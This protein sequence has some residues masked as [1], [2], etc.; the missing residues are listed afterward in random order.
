VC[1]GKDFRDRRDE[2]IVR[3]M[4]ETGARAGEVVAMTLDDVDLGHGSAVVRRGK[5]GKGRRIPI[6]PRTSASIDRYLRTRRSHLLASTPALWLGDRG[7]KFSYD[8]LER[9]PRIGAVEERD[10]AADRLDRSSAGL[11]TKSGRFGWFPCAWRP[12]LIPVLAG[13]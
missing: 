2:A 10:A 11:R 8:A 12:S 7:K 4:I 1:Q 3:L 9:H 5:G 6:G 13:R